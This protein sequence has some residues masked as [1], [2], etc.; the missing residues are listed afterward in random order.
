VGAL[1]RAAADAGAVFVHYSTDF[2]FDGLLDRP[3]EES[4]ATN[5]K[6]V[7]GTSKLLGEWLAEDAP[8]HYILRVESL[9][10]NAP[11]GPS[12]GSA[13]SI[14]ARLMADEEVVVFADRTVSPTHVMDAAAATR[15][16]VERRLPFGTYHC[17]NTGHGTWQE[18]AEEAA[19]MLGRRP[20]L[21]A[22]AFES[23][24]LRAPRPK[25]CALSNAKLARLGVAMP[26][27]RDALRRSLH[28]AGTAS[29]T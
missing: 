25:Y 28:E 19:R 29:A 9:F 17:V 1:A 11:N 8:R 16:V 24:Q 15:A 6:S 26:D 12:R 22:V 13:A 23:V 5:P 2:V 18:F 7:Y 10:G 3:Y 20:R 21:R 14:C 27:W 4:D